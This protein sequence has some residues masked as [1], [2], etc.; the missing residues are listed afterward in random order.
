MFQMK[1][2]VHFG[3]SGNRNSNLIKYVDHFNQFNKMIKL[4]RCG[5]QN[6]HL[7]DNQAPWL[8]Y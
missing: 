2:T 6:K 5:D 3:Y 4:N 7:K 8:F 1:F